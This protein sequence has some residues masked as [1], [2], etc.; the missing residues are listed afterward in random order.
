MSL[1]TQKLIKALPWFPYSEKRQVNYSVQNLLDDNKKTPEAR[2]PSR[3]GPLPGGVVAKC[4]A[5]LPCPPLAAAAKSGS[6]SGG[7]STSSG[8]SN[9][10]PLWLP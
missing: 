4:V 7:G 1:H 2:D 8:P 9:V 10:G 3:F 6:F 5:G